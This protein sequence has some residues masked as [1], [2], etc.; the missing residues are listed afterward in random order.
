[1]SIVAA[2]P[3]L[4]RPCPC[5]SRLRAAC[6]RGFTSPWRESIPLAPA[7]Y[8]GQWRC[9]DRSNGLRTVV[10][11]LADVPQR[12]GRLDPAVRVA[13]Y[14]FDGDLLRIDDVTA[15]SVVEQCQVVLTEEEARRTLDRMREHAREAAE[16]RALEAELDARRRDE[17]RQ[18]SGDEPPPRS[19]AQRRV[20]MLLPSLMALALSATA[21]PDP[22]GRGR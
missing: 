7:V 13:V 20:A 10:H 6:E 3:P 17:E 2:I 5:G 21:M 15:R 9:A 22:S 8:P 19:H 14:G 16:A 12:D 18:R 11:V 4:R 1:M